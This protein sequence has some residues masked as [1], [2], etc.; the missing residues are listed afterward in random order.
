MGWDL[1]P[2]QKLAIIL[3]SAGMVAICLVLVICYAYSR[4]YITKTKEEVKEKHTRNGPVGS[5]YGTNGTNAN[6]KNIV[7]LTQFKKKK[8]NNEEGEDQKTEED[9]FAETGV[10]GRKVSEGSLVSK[11]SAARQLSSSSG[12]SIESSLTQGSGKPRTSRQDSSYSS[13]SSGRT[14]P[15]PSPSWSTATT[16]SITISLFLTHIKQDDTTNNGIAAKLAIS[17]ESV[18]DLPSRE[19]KAH[20]DPWVSVSVLRDRRSLRRRPPANLAYFRTKTIRHAHN[21]F[22]SQTF[23]ADLQKNEIKDVSVRFTVMDQDRYTGPLELGHANVSLKEAKQTVPDPER[24]T[25]T[26]LLTQPKRDQ[27]EIQFG[28][29]YLPT[30]QRLSISLIKASSL[31]FDKEDK[32]N[33]E[34]K[35]DPYIKLLLFNQ[36]GRLVKKKKTTLKSATREPFFDE[37]VN[38]EAEPP[39]LETH[40]VMIILHSKREQED[41]G[42]PD[43]VNGGDHD[44]SDQESYYRFNMSSL[45]RHGSGSK[46]KDP[47]LGILCLGK[48]VKGEKERDHWNKMMDSPRKVF[49]EL[50]TLK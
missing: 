45:D 38:F 11:V 36:N 42:S 44:S 17:V 46:A 15:A 19:Y 4:C 30:A 49:T 22:Y 39:H 48:H 35:P 21:P 29:S 18:S 20:C 14:S 37:T 12:K 1:E 41:G 31:R 13:M 2:E 25:L 23:V 34:N 43:G 40:T 50:H 47:V 10:Y 8:E 16:P 28:M 24:S 26:L 7:K 32:A 5:S 6:A 27:G 33:A 3:T 9:K